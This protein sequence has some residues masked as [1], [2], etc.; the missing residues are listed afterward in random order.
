MLRSWFLI[1]FSTQRNEGSLE[2]RLSLGLEQEIHRMSPEY[3]A[4]PGSKEV[5]KNK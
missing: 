3:F 5:L 4:V 1:P 2:K